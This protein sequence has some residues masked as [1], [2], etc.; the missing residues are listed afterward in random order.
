MENLILSFNV[1]APMMLQMLVGYV[2]NKL[3]L[4]S[5]AARKELNKVIYKLLIPLSIFSSVYGGDLSSMLD[6]KPILFAMACLTAAFA[7]AMLVFGFFEPARN[8]KGVLVQA[9]VRS[10]FVIF[11]IPVATAL[12]GEGNLGVVSLMVVILSPYYNLL[13]V[14][15]LSVFGEKKGDLRHTLLNIVKNPIIIACLVAVLF[16]VTG[17]RLP[18]FLTKTISSLGG[19]AT[20]L[21]FLVL[22]GTFV[23]KTEKSVA[24]SVAAATVGKLFLMPLIF[25][26]LTIALGFRNDALVGLLA[27]FGAPAAVASY[28]LAV[29]MGGDGETASKIV[30]YTS[31]ISVVTMFLWIFLL[32]QMALL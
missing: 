6:P 24:R 1:V 30:V 15:A 20:P 16:M 27:L 13:S 32:K 9:I 26:P 10:N 12:L 31:A 21:A 25:L 28:P 18:Y 23:F 5:D 7:V 19:T 4:L 17:I 14:I 2:L 8:R 22:G 11:G 3:K 29:N